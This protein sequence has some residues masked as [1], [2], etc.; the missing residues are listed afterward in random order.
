MSA[1]E[2]RL[3]FGVANWHFTIIHPT[4]LFGQTNPQNVINMKHMCS[5]A[6]RVGEVFEWHD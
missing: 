6:T 4:F 2:Y 1:E 3:T 5:L